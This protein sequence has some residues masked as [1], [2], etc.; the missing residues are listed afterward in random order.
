MSK[1]VTLQTDKKHRF[2]KGALIAGEEIKFDALGLTDVAERHAEKLIKAGLL[3]VDKEDLKKFKEIL[4]INESGNKADVDVHLEN[5]KLK[6]Q[7]EILE[8]ENIKLKELIEDLKGKVAPEEDF[9]LSGM[10]YK[11][12]VEF[13]KKSDLPSKEWRNKKEEDLRSYIKGKLQK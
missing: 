8:K 5:I 6:E 7:V 4:E 10:N 12:L 11:E 9:G 13:C 2:G 3:P 1:I